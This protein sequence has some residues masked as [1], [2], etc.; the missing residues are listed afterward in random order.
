MTFGWF[1]A[2]QMSS[3]C[4][5]GTENTQILSIRD[6]QMAFRIFREKSEFFWNFWSEVFLVIDVQ[7]TFWGI[8]GKN[9]FV[10]SFSVFHSKICII[11]KLC[12]FWSLKTHKWF[13][14]VFAGKTF[15]AVFGL[16]NLQILVIREWLLWVFGS[17]KF[18]CSF[19]Q[20]LDPRIYKP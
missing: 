13:F 10:F 17:N 5:F 14:R 1:G 9:N 12:K 2:K 6:L 16:K 7:M 8:W 20:F 4:I 15:S 3:L 11:P 19:L 18:V